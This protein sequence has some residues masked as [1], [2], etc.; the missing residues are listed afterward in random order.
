MRH[1]KFRNPA[2]RGYALAVVAFSVAFGLRYG[3]A[4][5]I[6]SPNFLFRKEMAVK[7]G[8][9]FTLDPYSRATR[10]SYLLWDTTPDAELIDTLE[11]L[12]P[13]IAGGQ[14]LASMM[15]PALRAKLLTAMPA[16]KERAKTLIELVDSAYYLY[17][18]RPLALD[19][20]A[21]GLLG[22]GGRERLAGALPHLESLDEWTAAATEG[23]VRRFAESAGVKLG[24][25]AQPLRAAR[26][27]R[28][29]SD[30]RRVQDLVELVAE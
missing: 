27:G 26:H 14:A 7:D 10:L 15:T 9:G 12:L 11:K 24:Q 8:K 16:L 21:T 1:Q 25:V 19:E 4:Q 20:K 3:L 30:G 22:N 17:A 2:W 18:P 13:H 5:L 23:A 28:Q 29:V 6:Q